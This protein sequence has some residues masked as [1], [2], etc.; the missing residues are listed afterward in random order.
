MTV[1]LYD[2]SDDSRV[3]SKNLTGAVA[4]SVAPYGVIDRMNPVFVMDYDVNL[5][6]KNY[7]HCSDFNRYYF[8][9]DISVDTASRMY[10]NCSV[11]VLMSFGSAIRAC[12]ATV[13]RSEQ[14]LNR[15]VVD[16]KLPIDPNAVVLKTIDFPADPMSQ[17]GNSIII[18]V[19]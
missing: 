3:V 7:L 1:T 15:R 13:V 18:G 19:N 16:E 12:R 17:V 9:N 11:D 5:L 14:P 4:K 6:N 8:I 10:I 2:C